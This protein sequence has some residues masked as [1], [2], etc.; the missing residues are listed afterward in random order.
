LDIQSYKHLSKAKQVLEP[1]FQEL[2]KIKYLRSWELLWT[3]DRSD[4]KLVMTP[5]DKIMQVVRPRLG[6]VTPVED[7]ETSSLVKA[8]TD[9]GVR[10][11]DARRVVFDVDLRAQPVVDQIEWFDDQI[12]RG[13]PVKNPPGFLVACIRDNWRVPTEF[14]TSRKRLLMSRY[15]GQ[16]NSDGSEKSEQTSTSL[17]EMELRQQY[18]NWQDA[19]IEEAIAAQFPGGEYKKK[20]NQI[21]KEVRRKH[22]DLLEEHSSSWSAHAAAILR[23]QVGAALKLLTFEEFI[24]AQQPRLF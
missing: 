7:P 14:E 1:S 11:T 9:R 3:A 17:R 8:L 10:E 15:Q 5:G 2:I 19:Q 4:F 20:L 23:T 18:W 13:I 21:A 24:S 22:P 16:A 12:R 6:A